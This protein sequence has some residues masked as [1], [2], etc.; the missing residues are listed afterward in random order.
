MSVFDEQKR[1]AEEGDAEAQL[2]LGVCY[3][4]GHGVAQSDEQAVFWF[5]KAAEQGNATAQLFLALCYEAGRG[6]PQSDEQAVF[7]FKKAA[8]Q[9]DAEAQFNLGVCYDNGQGVEQSD[10]QAVFWYTKAAEQGDAAAQYNLGVC[11]K[12]GQGVA[13][14]LEQAVFWFRKAAEA[15]L[16][17]ARLALEELQEERDCRTPADGERGCRFAN[18]DKR[19]D[20]FISW[21]HRDKDVKDALVAAIEGL[22]VAKNGTADTGVSCHYRVWESDRDAEG[23]L[24]AVTEE[25]GRAK[26]FLLLLSENALKSEWVR[27]EAELAL[28]RVERGEWQ[29][30]NILVVYKDDV[31][32]RLPSLG[33]PYATLAH[34]A[35]VFPG[36]GM[37]GAITDRV[38][39]VLEAEALKAYER[40]KTAENQSFKAALRNQSEENDLTAD[41]SRSVLIDTLLTYEEGYVARSPLK[42]GEP[43]ELREF[44]TARESAYLYGEGGAGKSL[45]VSYLIREYFGKRGS[46]GR[47]LFF[48]HLNL[49]DCEEALGRRGTLTALLNGELNRYLTD[50][51]YHP[52]NPLAR[53]DKDNRV[54]VVLDGLDEIGDE[55]RRELVRR[56][57]EFRKANGDYRFLFVSRRTVLYEDLALIL[58]ELSLYTLPPFGK[59]E[60]TE[61]YCRI[62]GKVN[63]RLRCT[64]AE[65]ARLMTGFVALLDVLSEDVK[66]NPF[67]LSNLIFLYLRKR[68]REVPHNSHE[69]LARVTTLFTRELD[70]SKC[71]RFDYEYYLK[72]GRLA[73]AL[74]YIAFQKRGGSAKS[75]RELLVKY[76]GLRGRARQEDDPEEVGNAVFRYLA[77]RNIITEHKITHDIFTAYFATCYLYGKVYAPRD[78]ECDAPVLLDR[79]RFSEEL[80][81]HLG[82]PTWC[83]V[84]A[85]LLMKLDSEIHAYDVNRPMDE[86][87]PSYATF[88]ETLTCALR[89]RGYASEAIED[90]RSLAENPYGF[91][92]AET[93]KGYLPT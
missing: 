4:N 5:R 46:D 21:N 54:T 82:N 56:L 76:Y 20:L 67:L 8:E 91:Y 9:G 71:I 53:A 51:E 29:A 50:A 15:G 59:E 18:S 47:P 75:F 37:I 86:N 60:Q 88:D 7:W 19:S 38:T 58:G 16:E 90:V 74:E 77:R 27:K 44:A 42:D 24:D 84:A 31:A 23:T 3:H 2:F 35:A 55:A 93:V 25:I 48:L 41:G 32:A 63:A 13:Q 79:T 87:H 61:L 92:Y 72:N 52:A 68:G 12:N 40:Q 1:R 83:D 11:Y 65:E 78:E 17:E 73:R 62:F 45:L 14:S 28:S 80:R 33:E 81:E 22:D 85:G 57:G 66:R 36:D 39:N 10:E 49:I 30:E 89:E 64:A 70:E 69:I 34:Y 43:V 26:A 6:G